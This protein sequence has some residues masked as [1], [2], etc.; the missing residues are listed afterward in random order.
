MTSARAAVGPAHGFRLRE[1]VVRVRRAIEG[2]GTHVSGCGAQRLD[3]RQVRDVLGDAGAL[4]TFEQR[5]EPQVLD[6]EDRRVDQ[7][8]ESRA[9]AA[10]QRREHARQRVL[11]DGDVQDVVLPEVRRAERLERANR[12]LVTADFEIACG[13]SEDSSD[14]HVATER[15]ERGQ[16]RFAHALPRSDD[17]DAA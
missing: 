7:E 17:P 9:I 8:F 16:R 12:V 14:F 13:S 1:P 2:D 15:R 3:P 6:L 4:P 5:R 11:A 10:R